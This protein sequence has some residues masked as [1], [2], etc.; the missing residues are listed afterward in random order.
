VRQNSENQIFSLG[1]AEIPHPRSFIEVLLGRASI[2]RRDSVPLLATRKQSWSDFGL[3]FSS[4]V[5]QE[6][7][8][9][10]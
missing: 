10:H 5:Q 4:D 2:L 1:F 8:E 7:P 3:I 6:L 9:K